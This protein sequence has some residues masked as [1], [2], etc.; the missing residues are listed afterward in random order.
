VYRYTFQ[1]QAF[2]TRQY[3]R[4]YSLQ[5]YKQLVTFNIVSYIF[6]YSM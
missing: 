2:Q 1:K 6:I 4:Q 5:P 3:N